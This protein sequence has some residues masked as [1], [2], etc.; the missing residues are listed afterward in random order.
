MTIRCPECGTGQRVPHR[1]HENTGP[2]PEGRPAP[3]PA[4]RT[5]RRRPTP[6]WEPEEY[7][8]DETE[9]QEDEHDPTPLTTWFRNGGREELRRALPPRPAAAPAGGLAAILAAL[10]GQARPSAPAVPPRPSPAAPA[11]RP[12]PAPVPAPAL[13]GIQPVD[14]QTL[15]EKEVRRRDD[16]CQIARAL[17]GSMM[18]WYNQPPG[19]C[20]ALDTTQP[21]DRQRCPATASHIVRFRKDIT[22]ADA[23]VCPAHARP[24]AETAAHSPYIDAAIYRRR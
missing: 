20:E 4:A 21:R 18:V 6:R 7:E 19:L 13:S 23:Y 3:A 15:P 24:L 5:S 8:P 10:Q 2:R 22:E 9:D 17:S 12:A 14:P 16:V 11:P 1:T